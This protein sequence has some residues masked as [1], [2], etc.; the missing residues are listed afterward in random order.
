MSSLNAEVSDGYL[1]GAGDKLK[2]NVFDEPTLSGEFE[3][4]E[5]G[6]LALPLID[7]IVANGK[8]PEMLA[9]VVTSALKSGGY[10]LDP[11]VSVEVLKYRPFFI[12]GEVK[13]PGE[14]PYRGDL[15]L[16]QAVATA[17]G[18]T[19]RANK[20]TIEIQRKQWSVAKRVKLDDATLK[21]APGDTIT[22]LE[23][24]F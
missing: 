23:A 1:L 8:T 13:Q 9:Q 6:V 12:L 16:Q 19:A 2:V 11:H 7:P 15:T 3:V 20:R 21:I 5:G 14:Y 24:F 10:V 4:G 18:Y 22:V 17:G